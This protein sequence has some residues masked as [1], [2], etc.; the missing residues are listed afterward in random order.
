MS[1]PGVIYAAQKWPTNAHM[2]K[3]A[4]RLGY[5]R[6]DWL[7]LDATYGLGNFWTQWKPPYNRLVTL[8]Q[9][10]PAQIKADFTRLPFWSE[11]FD[12]VVFDP[13]Y[14]LNGTPSYADIPYGVHFPTRWQDRMALIRKGVHECARVTENILIVKCQDQVVSGKV[15]WRTDVVTYAA[16]QAGMTKVDRLDFLTNPRPQPHSR[17]LHA[18][19]NY[20][21]LTCVPEGDLI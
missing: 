16:Q 17:Q 6:S 7:I 9:Y 12:A 21:T 4:A 8:D 3:D 5:L 15:V 11:S 10:T 18:R 13:P 2:I 1:D 19:R 20:S 14:K